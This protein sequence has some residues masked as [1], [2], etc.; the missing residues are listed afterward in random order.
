M[1]ANRHNSNDIPEGDVMSDEMF[2]LFVAGLIGGSAGF[3][4]AMVEYLIR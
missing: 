1:G 2:T 3:L 4:I